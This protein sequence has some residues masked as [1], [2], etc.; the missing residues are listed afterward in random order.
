MEKGQGRFE[1]QFLKEYIF[2]QSYFLFSKIEFLL[3]WYG[4]S[5]C[6]IK[7]QADGLAESRYE[8]N[9]SHY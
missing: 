2:L 6:L 5:I 4:K 1:V 3:V 8:L 9:N 7:N